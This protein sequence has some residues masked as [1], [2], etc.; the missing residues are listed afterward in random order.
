MAVTIGQGGGGNIISN[1][2]TISSNT[3]LSAGTNWVSAGPIT[4]NSGVTVT[5]NGDWSVV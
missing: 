4:I 3:T 5:V 1:D 2:T